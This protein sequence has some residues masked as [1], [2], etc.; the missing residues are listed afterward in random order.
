MYI[1]TPFS[2]GR[3]GWEVPLKLDE[4]L[5]FNVPPGLKELKHR[6]CI[7]VHI[8]VLSVHTA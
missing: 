1:S 5:Y 3:Q 4:I 6:V 7:I 2:N 8:D